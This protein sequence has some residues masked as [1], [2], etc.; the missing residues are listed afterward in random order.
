[1]KSDRI[2]RWSLVLV[3]G[4][5][6]IGVWQGVS[7]AA[8]AQDGSASAAAA[9][10]P[11]NVAVVRIESVVFQLQERTDKLAELEKFDDELQSDITTIE[12]QLRQMGE[13]AKVLAGTPQLEAL[14]LQAAEAKFLL[15]GR[16]ELKKLR[17]S[18]RDKRL[19]IGMLQKV[20]DAVKRYAEREGIEIVL[21]NDAEFELEMDMHPA[22]LETRQA[23]WRV[24][25]ASAGRDIS[26]E[27][28][29]M[30]NNEYR[31]ASP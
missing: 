13:E 1:M 5:I 25:Y 3:L 11:T 28:A 19:M 18:E 30:M 9:T 22:T 27:V 7:G 4:V 17:V 31:N 16:R 8:M 2:W 6:G 21:V 26:D 12:S 10:G 20:E 29:T 23:T 24:V 15:D 14:L